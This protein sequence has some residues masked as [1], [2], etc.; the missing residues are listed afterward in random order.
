MQSLTILILKNK[1]KPNYV[2]K[3][4][5]S[6]FILLPHSLSFFRTIAAPQ[7][8]LCCRNYFPKFHSFLW[9]WFMVIKTT[10]NYLPCQFKNSQDRTRSQV[11]WRRRPTNSRS[12]SPASHCGPVI[13][14]VNRGSIWPTP[15]Q[16]LEQ[17]T[18][19][20]DTHGRSTSLHHRI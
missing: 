12:A 8:Q 17:Q 5:S 16:P 20:Q 19:S 13:C 3:L 11:A 15:C 6:N 14:G 1:L 2:V 9:P 7:V 18:C 4:A 10:P